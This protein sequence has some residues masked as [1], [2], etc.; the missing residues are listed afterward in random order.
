MISIR[1][2]A[3]GATFILQ[4]LFWPPQLKA[5]APSD[6]PDQRSTASRPSAPDQR[7]TAESLYEEAERLAQ[8]GQYG[9]ARV[10]VFAAARLWQQARQPGKAAQA[11]RQL[12][13]RDQKAG[14]WQAALQAYRQL[15]QVKPLSRQD[16]VAA[17]NST[18]QVYASLYQFR[19]ASNYFQQALSL[20]RQAA[21]PQGQTMAL[22]GLATIYA[23][24]G[25]N[26]KAHASLDAARRLNWRA[27]AG[28]TEG[29]ALYLIGQSYREQGQVNEAL[30]ALTQALSHYRQAGDQAGEAASLC[31][32][33]EAHLAAGQS[34]TAL[35]QARQAVT[36][37]QGLKAEELQWRA[38]L[39][40]ARAQRA[41]DR[42]EEA[43]T[44]YLR[45]ISFIEKQR[46]LA[47]SADSLRISMLAARQAPYRELTELSLLRGRED[48]A[49][50]SLELARARATLDL[51]TQSRQDRIP[52]DFNDTLR[53]LSRR[54][55]Q[56]RTELLT[57]Y[58]SGLTSEQLSARRTE[59]AE[60]EQRLEEARW[61]AEAKRLKQFTRPLSL[62]QAQE[63]LLRPQEVMLEFS[64]GEDR[65]YVWL[66]S[67]A[68]SHW[69]SLPGQK[70]IEAQLLPY[71]KTL[72]LKPQIMYLERALAEQK[73]LG[74]RIFRLL[75]GPLAERLKTNQRLLI[76][77][78]GPLYYLPFETLVRDGR[79]LIED[80]EI[81]YSPSASV[82]GVLRSAARSSLEPKPMS[83]LAFGDPVFAPPAG[84]GINQGASSP[85]GKGAVA[86]SLPSNYRLPPLPYT[87]AEVMAIS[88]LFSP[89]RRRLYLGTLSTE[90]SFKREQL[91][92]YRWL[93]FA[94]HSLIDEQFPTRSG[95]VLAQESNATE[96]GFLEM[97]EIADLDL[98]CDLVVLSACKTGRGQL[99]TGEGIV[100]LARAFL[101]AGARSVAVSLWDVSDAATA[102]L[103]SDFY[104]HLVASS[105]GALALRQ[106]K[107]EALRS[108]RAMRH[109]YYW[110]PFVIVGTSQ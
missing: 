58:P 82:L 103:M 53:E 60:I 72:L 25:S 63:T 47:L 61:E 9:L 44:S 76:M 12:A 97:R 30:Q 21:E 18:A 51:L 101:Y 99:V 100:G 33:S 49:F 62:K 89:E 14:H 43:T 28:Q 86:A 17:L 41:G 94:T 42:A 13:E 23:A 54:S 20:A 48:E 24:Q 32:L 81:S 85:G 77:P 11:L 104:R 93:H 27:G 108:S 26:H 78:D 83:L 90:A 98:D 74:E 96:D 95:V 37:A 80:H 65:S 36:L 102:Q 55:A 4:S 6:V 109:P 5:A 31:A 52:V 73:A 7:Q 8:T 71:L 39:A 38:W 64:L 22:I 45:S 3:I 106:A 107:L 19:I 2:L 105:S 110:A 35:A 50:R 70:E 66:V 84:A 29:T 57:S 87:R 67:A 46:V 69:A 59:L 15:L 16:K 34:Q 10:K 40:L 92:R 91:G 68:E 88:G 56:L 1:R 79:Y 75:L